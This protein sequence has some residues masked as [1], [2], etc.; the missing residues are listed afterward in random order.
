MDLPDGLKKW[1]HVSVLA[2]ATIA[3][4]SNLRL[5]LFKPKLLHECKCLIKTTTPEAAHAMPWAT[6]KKKMTDKG[7]DEGP[8][9]WCSNV[10]NHHYGPLVLQN[11][12]KEQPLWTYQKGIVQNLKNINIR[13][14][15]MEMPRLRQRVYRCGNTGGKPDNNVVTGT[16]RYTTPTRQVEFRIDVVSCAA[17]VARA[18]YRL[19]PSEMKELAEQLQELT[20]K[21][22]I[23][24]SS[25]PWGAPVLFVKKKDSNI[26][27]K[28]LLSN[29]IVKI[30]SHPGK[31]NVVADALSRKERE[32]LRVRALNSKDPEEIHNIKL[33][34]TY[35]GNSMM[36]QWQ[37]VWLPFKAITDCKSSAPRKRSQWINGEDVPKRVVTKQAYQSQLSDDRDPRYH[38][39]SGSHFRKALV[40]RWQ[41]HTLGPEFSAR[42]NGRESF[43]SRKRIQAAADRQKSYA[44]LKRK[45]MKFQVGDKVMLKVSPWKGVVRFGKRGK[46]NPRYVGPFKVLKK[47]GAVAYKL[48]LPQEL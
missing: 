47:V 5:A 48:E 30:D 46:L 28:E 6:L 26:A 24:P 43:K 37:G 25:S 7:Q 23:R 4:Q 29:T 22:F 13:G 19:A 31:A 15:G 9:P 38:Q 33:E 27:G 44:D 16:C 2:I 11:A 20:D 34:P 8:R 45:P 10:T 39:I 18:P 17:P 41:V 3:I 35:G 12:N 36:P 40:L 1:S 42:N 21:G 32:P 14:I